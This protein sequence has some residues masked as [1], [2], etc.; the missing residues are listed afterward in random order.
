MGKNVF[1][2]SCL[3]LLALLSCKPRVPS[4]YIQ[5]EEMEDILY[6]YYI[7]DG[8]ANCEEGEYQE[9]V[10][11]TGLYKLA[12]LKKHGIT[13]A[14]FDSSLI[15]YSR[16]ADRLHAIYENIEKRLGN[17]AISMGASSG[18]L[19]QFGTSVANS[20]TTDI[21]NNERACVLLP[22]SP[23]N[24]LSYS[25]KADT[26]YHKGDRFI[27][28]FDTHFIYQDGTKDGVAMLALRLS[29][30]S[31]VSHTIHLSSDYHYTLSIVD[32]MH[33]GIKDVYGFIFLAKTTDTPSSTMKLMF[34]DN[35]RLVRLH[36]STLSKTPS[37]MSIKSTSVDTVS[38]INKTGTGHVDTKVNETGIKPIRNNS[39]NIRS[40]HK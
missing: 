34:V 9:Q 22:Q 6:D 12:V 26:A 40:L 8:M 11:N 35:I 10:Y 30:D 37:G 5:P 24:V 38:G 13:Q 27:L 4:E 20:D 19:H 1:I 14:E 3:A 21:W 29:N 25:L 32:D 33:L 36:N 16:H 15:Y 31:I 7:A 39:E 28:S 18:G 17:A 2:V 23:F